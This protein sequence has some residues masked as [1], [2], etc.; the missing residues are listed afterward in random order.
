MK[1][2]SVLVVDDHPIYCKGITDTLKGL[3]YIKKL[4]YRH[5]GQEALDFLKNNN[6][7]LVFLD[8]TMPVLDGTETAK[9]VVKQYPDTKIIILTSTDSRRSIYNLLKLGVQGYLLKGTDQ[10]EFEKAIVAVM[11][12]LIYLNPEVEQIYKAFLKDKSNQKGVKIEAV[13]L[14]DR[15]IE[16]LRQICM[17]KTNNAIAEALFLSPATINNHRYNIFVKTKTKNAV[18][19]AM[20]AVRNGYFNPDEK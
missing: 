1:N 13:L 7:D 15:E 6:V 10:Q 5:N 19:L 12:D 9:V 11:D 20:F 17:Q 8:L 16:V 2:L 4:N 14:T 3:A 18:G